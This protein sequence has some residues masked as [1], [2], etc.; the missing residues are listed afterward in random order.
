MTSTITKPPSE[1]RRALLTSDEKSTWPGESIKL[2]RW[3]YSST[4]NSTSPFSFLPFFFLTSWP[5]NREMED[6]FIVMHLYCSSSLE[7]RY[8]SCPAN[9]LFM[10][11][12]E[13][14]RESLRVVFPWSTCARM[15]MFLTRS[16]QC[17]ISR[18]L[19]SHE[20][21]TCCFQGGA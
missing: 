21:P 14:M 5:N 11:W 2:T 18:H 1:S 4:S 13:L 8:L 15:Q 12:F 10:M 20:S 9:L 3:C 19:S 7:S 6:A 17:Y 16:G